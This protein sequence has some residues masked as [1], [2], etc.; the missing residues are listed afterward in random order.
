MWFC[1]N[2]RF[3]RPGSSQSTKESKERRAKRRKFRGREAQIEMD[4]G[5]KKVEEME[6]SK[7]TR[8]AIHKK[9]EREG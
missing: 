3:A 6:I 4:R 8:K 1:G 5:K 2:V 7:K 9:R